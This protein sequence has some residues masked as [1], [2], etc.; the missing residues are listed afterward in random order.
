MVDFIKFSLPSFYTEKLLNNKSLDFFYEGLSADGVLRTS[1]KQGHKITPCQNAYIQN[2]RV[3]IYDTGRIIVDGSVHKFWNDGRHNFNDFRIKD[4][5]YS[6]NAIFNILGV[7]PEDATLIIAEFGVNIVVPF[8][9]K[10]FMS[11][12]FFHK[13]VA[14]KWCETTSEG[15]Y[16]QCKHSKYRIKIYDKF[17]P[18]RNNYS[19][20]KNLIRFEVNYKSEL[21]RNQFSIHTI[22]DLISTDFNKIAKQ[23]T[24]VFSLILFYD[25]TIEHSSVRLLKY[26]NA[27]YW[28]ALIDRKRTS[29]YNKHRGL[30]NDFTHQHSDNILKQIIELIKI[31]SSELINGSVLIDPSSIGATNTPPYSERICL[32][33]GLDISM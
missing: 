12:L 4:F 17:T 7:D 25:F 3:K 13:K 29:A 6:I 9:I 27:N 14:F 18:Y 8:P 15:I 5:E 23:L 2:I 33:T 24:V 1:N 30:L 26:S 10:Q 16:Y 28:A 19:P 22:A 21:L 31:K 32:F 20:P 11:N